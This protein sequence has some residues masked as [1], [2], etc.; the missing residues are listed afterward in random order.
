MRRCKF[1]SEVE[2]SLRQ[3]S[4]LGEFNLMLFNP[5]MSQVCALTAK[6][7]P[8]VMV[9]QI[10]RSVSATFHEYQHG[11]DISNFGVIWGTKTF[12]L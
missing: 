2:Y 10:P 8:L 12:A 3:V 6:K 7:E 11:V 4:E 5:L 1:V 9:P